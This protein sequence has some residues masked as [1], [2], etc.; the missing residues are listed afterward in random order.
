MSDFETRSERGSV[1]ADKLHATIRFKVGW[2]VASSCEDTILE[3]IPD[4]S[5]AQMDS[6]LLF[7][8]T[9]LQ[10]GYYRLCRRA[11]LRISRMSRKPHC[12]YPARKPLLPCVNVNSGVLHVVGGRWRVS[13]VSSPFRLRR[14]T[15]AA[16][17]SASSRLSC[18]PPPLLVCAADGGFGTSVFAHLSNQVLQLPVPIFSTTLAVLQVLSPV[19]LLRCELLSSAA[20]A[21]SR[22]HLAIPLRACF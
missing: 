1:E 4:S 14:A 5:F 13:N 18:F 2:V 11:Q 17:R 12:S 20:L 8:D 9:L 16:M 21:S 22:E 15:W 10:H 6:A 7:A 3:R 19:I